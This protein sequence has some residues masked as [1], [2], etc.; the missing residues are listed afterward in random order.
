MLSNLPSPFWYWPKTGIDT[1]WY[2]STV[3]V[4]QTQF[5]NWSEVISSVENSLAEFKDFF[6]A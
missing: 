3:L 5:G 1:P 6:S 2:P 4:R